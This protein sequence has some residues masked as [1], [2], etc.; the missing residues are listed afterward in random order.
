MHLL[1]EKGQLSGAKAHAPVTPQCTL[2]NQVGQCEPQ[3]KPATE[4]SNAK[5]YSFVTAG[6]VTQNNC[7][8]S[9]HPHSFI[10]FSSLLK[11]GMEWVR[12]YNK[13]L[14]LMQSLSFCAVV[15]F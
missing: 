6:Q 9:K 15:S 14:H 11:L 8:L 13:P 3:E 10:V 1:L 7:P 5:D 12:I 4:S 2:S